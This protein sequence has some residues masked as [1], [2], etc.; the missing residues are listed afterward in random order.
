MHTE[1]VQLQDPIDGVTELSLREMHF[2]EI[3]KMND[4]EKRF[5]Q[6]R[7][8]KNMLAGMTHVEVATLGKLSQS[9]LDAV[10]DFFE[11]IPKRSPRI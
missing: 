2:D 8:F 1:T 5:G 11:N 4:D 6:L 10:N 7:A 3:I 9:D